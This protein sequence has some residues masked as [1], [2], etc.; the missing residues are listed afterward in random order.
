MGFYNQ[1]EKFDP[2]SGDVPDRPFSLLPE[3]AFRARS[4]LKSRTT[5]Q[6]GAVAKAIDFAIYCYFDELKQDEVARLRE[7]LNTPRRWRRDPPNVE[8]GYD[9]ALQF[10][11]W[12]GEDEANGCW[13][14]KEDMEGELSIPTPGNTSEVVALK[15]CGDWAGICREGFPDGEPQELFA[16]LALWMLADSIAWLRRPLND[17]DDAVVGLLKAVG[18]DRQSCPISYSLAGEYALKAMEAVCFAEHLSEMARVM[19]AHLQQLAAQKEAERA[20]RSRR[21]EALNEERHR[22]TYEARALAI[23]EFAKDVARF[24]SAEKH[25][26]F[27]SDWLR[28]RGLEYEPRTVTGWIRSYAKEVGVRFR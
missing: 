23:T 13:S 6:I 26:L 17:L 21:A 7:V 2:V 12:D 5:E 19:D 11:E 24:P 28:E 1:F 14:F 15:E 9:Y 27:L 10:F 22:K 18:G 8:A 25:G 20:Q 3:I 16:A 4:L